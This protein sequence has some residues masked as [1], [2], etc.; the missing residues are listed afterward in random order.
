MKSKV[1]L[2]NVLSSNLMRKINYIL[3]IIGL[4]CLMASYTF[5]GDSYWWMAFMIS[6]IILIAIT[7]CRMMIDR[8]EF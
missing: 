8:M 6:G 1:I 7:V 4:L 5:H 3:A 2:H